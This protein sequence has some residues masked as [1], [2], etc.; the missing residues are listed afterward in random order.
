MLVLNFFSLVAAAIKIRFVDEIVVICIIA[1][2]D[3]NFVYKRTVSIV[4]RLFLY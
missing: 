2:S 3:L 4:C 1:F